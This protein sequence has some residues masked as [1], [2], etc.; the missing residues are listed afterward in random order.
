MNPLQETFGEGSGDGFI[1][2]STDPVEGVADSTSSKSRRSMLD[3][4][5]QNRKTDSFNLA[6]G[7]EKPNIKLNHGTKLLIGRCM[8]EQSLTCDEP[9]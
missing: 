9:K 7:N 2:I 8:A 4:M 1:S 3:G 6:I 5:I